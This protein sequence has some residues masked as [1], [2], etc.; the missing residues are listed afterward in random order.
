MNMATLNMAAITSKTEVATAVVP[1]AEWLTARKELLRKEKEFTRLSSSR[2]RV[3]SFS[4]RKS[5]LRAVSHSAG[6]TTAVATSVLLVIAAIFNVAMF[7]SPFR[8]ILRITL[9]PAN[10]LHGERG[11][12]ARRHHTARQQPCAGHASWAHRFLLV[13]GHAGRL[14]PA[15]SLSPLAH[16]RVHVGPALSHAL[17]VIVRNKSECHVVE[18]DQRSP[19]F[20]AQPVLQIRNHRIRHEQRSGDFDKRRPLDGLH[21][22]PE[23]AVAITQ[24]AVP[25]SAGPRLDLHRHSLA[26]RCVI[27]RSKLF[28]QRRERHLQRRPHVNFLRNVCCQTLNARCCCRVHRSSLLCF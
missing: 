18:L 27:L 25:P 22:S 24:V 12:P 1:P 20:F 2:S 26:L 4:L 6:G 28:Q 7:I 15:L 21:V 16:A 9:L 19:I 3:N 14:L 8:H 11:N 23:M 10:H 17:F 5:S 13:C